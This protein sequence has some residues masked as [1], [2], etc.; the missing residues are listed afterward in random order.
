MP[1]CVHDLGNVDIVWT[2]NAAGIAGS[3]DPDRL[4]TKNPF[5]MAILNMSENLIWK[6]IHR[7]RH[8]AAGRALLA[9]VASLKVDPARPGNLRK[10][11]IF[12][13]N[14]SFV[15]I[16]FSP[17]AKNHLTRRWGDTAT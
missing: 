13:R 11:C 10:K 16:H 9:L 8:R 7:I 6:E 12:L 14:H 4:G 3:A 15:Q 2:S 17:L 1:Q 5:V